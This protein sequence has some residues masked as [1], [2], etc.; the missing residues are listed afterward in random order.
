MSAYAVKILIIEEEQFAQSIC[1]YL[2]NENYACEIVNN[3]IDGKRRIENFRYDCIVLS[4]GASDDSGLTFL[5]DLKKYRKTEGIIILAEKK[6]SEYAAV[7]LNLGADDYLAKPFHP[8]ELSARI[9]SVIRR[10]NA[11]NNDEIRFGNLKINT[12]S[13]IVSVDDKKINLTR[14][15]Y[16]L[17]IILIIN[18][19]RAVAK[20]EIAQRL[21]GQSAVYLYNFDILYTHVKNL[22]RKL[23]TAGDYIKNV[24]ATGYILSD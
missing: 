23:L 5:N 22:K 11:D 20:E 19:G 10:K 14:T 24:Y 17:L 7:L 6:S 2:A 3:T 16:N 12:L 13:R 4:N 1:Q 18:R 8:A 15:E 9:R 21:T